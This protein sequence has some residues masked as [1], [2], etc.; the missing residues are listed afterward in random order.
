M[1]TDRMGLFGLIAAAMA[2]LLVATGPALGQGDQDSEQA[3]A[4]PQDGQGPPPG[5]PPALV[6]VDV[7]RKETIQA[8]REVVGRLVEVRRAMVAAEQPGRVVQVNAEEGDKVKADDT[9]LARIDDVW[10]SLALRTAEAELA[11]ERASVLAET[12]RLNQAKRDLEFVT[13]VFESGSITQ[14]ELIDAEAL[15]RER[16]ASLAVAQATVLAA[17]VQEDRCREDLSRLVVRAPFDGVVVRKM[18]EVGQW[19]TVGATVAEIISV[20]HVDALVDV[21]EEFVNHLNR[22]LEVEVWVESLAATVTGKV[23]SITPMGSVS[24]RTFP[25]K[26][27]LNDRDGSFK[28]GMSVIAH[29]P[30]GKMLEQLTVPRDAV[31]RTASGTVVWVNLE[32]KAMPVGVKILFGVKD[33]FVVTPVGGGP[34]LLPG[35]RVVTEGA[36]RL[37][38]TQPLN[39]IKPQTAAVGASSAE[40]REPE[41]PKP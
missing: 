35:A 26:I 31:K 12:A 20:G 18:T 4:R 15:V 5:P 37:F 39:V 9:V 1:A 32:G 38:P 3:G 16:Q 8:R 34:P 24:A 23:A 27:R 25:V 13:E 2:V 11:Q 7:V 21:P 6:Q 19:V 30:T 36:E 40:K 14:K 29:V 33:R 17:S 28:P 10:A 41:Q 22:G